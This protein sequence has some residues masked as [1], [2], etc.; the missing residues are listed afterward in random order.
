[1]KM[2]EAPV[3]K[4]RLASPSK[5][6]GRTSPIKEKN[7]ALPSKQ[8]YTE[9]PSKKKS[10]VEKKMEQ[11]FSCTVEQSK[12]PGIDIVSCQDKPSS[13]RIIIELHDNRIFF[14]NANFV[15]ILDIHFSKV[16][17]TISSNYKEIARLPKLEYLCRFK[18]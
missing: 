2:V 5:Q 15:T 18:R 6:K 4:S 16:N 9:S 7:A 1:M 17:A 13:T 11:Y 14:R 10:A 12:I 3:L 8:N